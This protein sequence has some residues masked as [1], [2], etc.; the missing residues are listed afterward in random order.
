MPTASVGAPPVRES[1]VVSPTLARQ[2]LERAR[3][4]AGSP[5]PLITSAALATSSPISAAGELIAK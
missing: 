3:R 1:R 2:W 5:S 4:R